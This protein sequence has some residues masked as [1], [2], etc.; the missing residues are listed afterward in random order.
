MLLLSL[1]KLC[2]YYFKYD[3]F[4]QHSLIKCFTEL[5]QLIITTSKYKYCLKYWYFIIIIVS[6]NIASIGFN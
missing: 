1:D 5:Q 2:K 6:Q 4:I 3:P